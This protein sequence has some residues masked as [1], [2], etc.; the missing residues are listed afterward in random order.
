MTGALPPLGLQTAHSIEWQKARRGWKKR[1][2]IPYW[3]SRYLWRNMFKKEYC[4]VTKELRLDTDT[5]VCC[6]LK[7]DLAFALLH[8]LWLQ[9]LDDWFS[10]YT[11]Y[12]VSPWSRKLH[13]QYLSM[14]WKEYGNSVVSES[15]RSNLTR[16]KLPPSDS[17]EDHL[18]TIRHGTQDCLSFPSICMSNPLRR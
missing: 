11:V 12:H 14:T 18:W 5:G 9:K 16:L 15:L 10:K 7:V 1:K 8:S 17:S 6:H 3:S 4:N 2:E 13:Y